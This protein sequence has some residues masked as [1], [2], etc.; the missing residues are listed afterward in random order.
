MPREPLLVI[1]KYFTYPFR[2]FYRRQ[3]ETGA[4]NIA[5]AYVSNTHAEKPTEK[6]R[7]QITSTNANA[8]PSSFASEQF[9]STSGSRRRSPRRVLSAV[10]LRASLERLVLIRLRARISKHMIPKWLACRTYKRM[11]NLPYNFRRLM[12]DRVLDTACSGTRS[13]TGR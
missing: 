13:D 4:R 11:F 6:E 7:R 2:C 8:P 9:R 5:V 3:V 10:L 12:L 1:T